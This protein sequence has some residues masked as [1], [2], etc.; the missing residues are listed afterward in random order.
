VTDD[1]A[2]LGFTFEIRK[3]GRVEIFHRSLRAATL[4]GRVAR[5]F[6]EDAERMPKPE[7]QQVMARL[8]GNYK[9]GNER[10]AASHPR[11]RRR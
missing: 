6:L 5:E 9:R 1:G 8:T 11:N 10:S 2:D 7:L 4:R 3:D